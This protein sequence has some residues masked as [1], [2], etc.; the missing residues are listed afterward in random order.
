MDEQ[1][2]LT[3]RFDRHHDRLLALAQQM[4]GPTRAAD[5]ALLEAR[6][7]LTRPAADEQLT[8]WLTMLVGRVCVDALRA[9]RARRAAGL[10]VAG[11]QP[12]PGGADGSPPGEVAGG[13][14]AGGE[15]AG[16]AGTDSGGA[17]ASASASAGG[18]GVAVAGEAAD[19]AGLALLVVLESLAPAERLVLV[20]HDMFGV[21]L[22]EVA[23]I[24]GRT[25]AETRE[26]LDRTQRRVRGG[27]PDRDGDPVVRRQ[28]VEAFLAAALNA[29][30]EALLAVLDT[31]VVVRSDAAPNLVR[32]ASA[33]AGNAASFA[34]IARIARPALVDGRPGVVAAQ[35]EEECR[36]LTFEIVNEMIVE[37][38]IITDPERVRGL[39][40]TLLG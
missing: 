12:G 21:P 14:V 8:G 35:G 22:E 19:S 37:I 26:L 2:F 20:L 36:V 6:R 30:V 34:R 4:L 18:T 27:A 40:L 15:G 5:E 3:E 33:V 9:R 1:H 11:G 31:D 28:V 32:G 10:E 17:S 24:V 13:E 29:D 23:G 16:S 39:D 38:G 25:P 7:R